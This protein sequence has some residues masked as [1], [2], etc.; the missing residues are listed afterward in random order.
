MDGT[1]ATSSGEDGL[2]SELTVILATSFTAACPATKL[3]EATVSSFG[4]VGGLSSCR[5]VVVAD[6]YRVSSRRR[7]KA[8]RLLESDAAPY[9]AY[10]QALRDL[11]A[12][13]P[14]SSPW[15][16]A[17]VLEL[18]SHHGFGWAI[19]AALESG[20][21]KTPLI[22]VVQHDRSFMQAFDMVRAV[23]CMLAD[24]RVKYLLLPTRSTT[25]H[26]QTIAHRCNVHLPQIQ[27]LGT[28]LQQ[29]GFWWD[30]THLATVEHYR[31]FVLKQRCVKR[32]TFPEDTLGRQ[33]LDAVKEHG[34]AG[35]APYGAYV[36]D[37][38]G[39]EECRTVGHLNGAHWRA[40]TDEPVAEDGSPLPNSRQAHFLRGLAAMQAA[41]EE[42]DG[43]E[44]LASTPPPARAT[45][46]VCT[47]STH[48]PSERLYPRLL[49][50]PSS[51]SAHCCLR[52]D[53]FD[54]PLVSVILPIHNGE[55]WI[56][57][58]LEGLL[59]QTVCASSLGEP[60]HGTGPL[61]LL[62]LSAY[63][64]GST[65]ATWA[66]L[67]EWAPRMRACGWR[68]VLGR[69]G[70]DF[71]GGCGFSK[72]RAVAQSSG[73]W[74]CF[75]DVDDVSL[76]ERIAKQLAA[77]RQWPDAL[78]GSRVRR[79]PEGST[80]RYIKWANGMSQEQLLLHRFKE[81]TLLMPTWFLSRAS[82][83]RNGGFREE[84]C[85]D[86]LFL[87]RHALLGAGLHRVDE[88]LVVYRYHAAAATHA[89]PR[90]TIFRHRAAAIEEAVLASWD[91]F[92]IW[93]AGND[94]REFFKTLT[95]EARHKVAAFCDIDPKKVGTTYQYFEHAVPIVHFSEAQPPLVICVAL[96]RTDGAFEANLASLA[97]REGIDYFHFS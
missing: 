91:R 56:D 68:V 40:W 22:L 16:R 87:Q 73:R 45:P 34:L 17:H 64:D 33:M 21:V 80:A 44:Q 38:E 50:Q 74:L 54:R 10:V 65:D 11:A 27:V 31:D 42:G 88:V 26:A 55:Q 67:Q 23:R 81:C 94:G 70:R 51:T 71:G 3:I 77:A 19:K 4:F 92:T 8:G 41:P 78:I 14:A 20:L 52:L 29:L 5:L 36:W 58:C 76:P 60:S 43:V 12:H 69:S 97:L 86:L 37:D 28:T 24:E 96:D 90:R 59:R 2:S 82:F 79:E 9:T 95:P 1:S 93:G 62:E 83:E 18:P 47:P 66:R 61:P 57:G 49:V 84:K 6:G 25:N 85:E 39:G 72:N 7:T 46:A 75:Q 15:S 53:V 13:A 30:S 63:D 89:I 48:E 32:G 35:A